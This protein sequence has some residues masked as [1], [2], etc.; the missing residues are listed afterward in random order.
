MEYSFLKPIQSLNFGELKE[1]QI[2]HYSNLIANSTNIEQIRFL[3][4][5]IKLL[6]KQK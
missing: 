3:T 1:F 5:Q 4:T 2:E 6:C